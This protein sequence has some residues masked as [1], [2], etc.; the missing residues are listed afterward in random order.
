MQI[1]TKTLMH[2]IKHISF[3]F[4][5]EKTA[6]SDDKKHLHEMIVS[7]VSQIL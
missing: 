1:S 4:H 3:L 6:C 5:Y 2:T 7:Q